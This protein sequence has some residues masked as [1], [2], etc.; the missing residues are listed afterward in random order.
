MGE[1]EGAA[2]GEGEGAAE[3]EGEGEHCRATETLHRGDE[4]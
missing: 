2:E 3:G 4:L 1:G